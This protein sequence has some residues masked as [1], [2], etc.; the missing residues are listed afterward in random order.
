MSID[1]LDAKL[2]EKGGGAEIQNLI[3]VVSE[4][5]ENSVVSGKKEER[6]KRR[7]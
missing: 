2:M 6:D 4:K 5:I 7:M 1:F 3:F